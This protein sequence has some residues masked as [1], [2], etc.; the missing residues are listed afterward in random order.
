MFRRGVSFFARF[1]NNKKRDNVEESN[2]AESEAGDDRPEGADV[3]AFSR[4]VD[5]ISFNPQHPQPPPY[6]KVRAKYRKE[7]AFDRVFLAQELR[8]ANTQEE[9]KSAANNGERRL[10]RIT[11][12]EGNAVWAMEFSK[13]GRYLATAGQD[14]KIRIWSVLASRE[15]RRAFEKEED[16]GDGRSQHIHLS[17][18]VFRSQPCRRFESHTGPVLDLSWS[19]VRHGLQQLRKLY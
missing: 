1:I 3:Q 7:R 18:P 12:A 14:K 10:K 5:N 9:G 16:A 13:D 17:A 15:D 8:E 4:D 2:Y 6:I 11:N 19:K